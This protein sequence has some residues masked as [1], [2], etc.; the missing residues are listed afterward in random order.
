[1][2]NFEGIALIL[3]TLW[4]HALIWLYSSVCPNCAVSRRRRRKS[5]LRHSP[6]CCIAI[7]CSYFT[8]EFCLFTIQCGDS[9]IGPLI[10]KQ[11]GIPWKWVLARL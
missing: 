9:V 8:Y 1:M 6:D 7:Q 10:P 4:L 11:A 3:Y 2:N 5:D